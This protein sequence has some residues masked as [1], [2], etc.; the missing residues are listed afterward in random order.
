MSKCST[1]R[2]GYKKSC[3]LIFIFELSTLSCGFCGLAFSLL[4]KLGSHFWKTHYFGHC[5]LLIVS[6]R[7]Q[8]LKVGKLKLMAAKCKTV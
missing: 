4:G 2:A 1:S 3:L 5:E 6:F 8:N 7:G